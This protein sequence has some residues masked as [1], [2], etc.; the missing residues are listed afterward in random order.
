MTIEDAFD[1]DDWENWGKF[2]A[3][4]GDKVQLVTTLFL[5]RVCVV[6]GEG[7]HVCPRIGSGTWL[8]LLLFFLCFVLLCGGRRAS[9]CRAAAGCHSALS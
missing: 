3:M 4:I 2:N 9:I 1:E 5:L 7:G 8:P 6:L